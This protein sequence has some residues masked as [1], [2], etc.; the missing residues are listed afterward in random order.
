MLPTLL[1]SRPTVCFGR[2]T[3]KLPEEPQPQ[4]SQ[5][6]QDDLEVGHQAS[7]HAWQ[8]LRQTVTFKTLIPFD[9]TSTFEANARLAIRGAMFLYLAGVPN[10]FQLA[11]A[12]PFFENNPI[13][14]SASIVMFVFT[15][16]KSVGET[17]EFAG[18]G[19]VGAVL[20]AIAGGLLFLPFP[21]GVESSNYDDPA[22]LFATLMAILTVFSTLLLNLSTL[23]Q[24]FM[25]S[26]YV[27]HWMQFVDPTRDKR[28][29]YTFLGVDLH[30]NV[31]IGLESVKTSA[32]GCVLA[33]LV[34]LLPYPF[35]SIRKAK[36]VSKDMVSIFGDTWETALAMY[37]S[38]SAN[39]HEQSKIR[40]DLQRI[41]THIGTF[42]SHIT[43]SWWEAVFV[44]KYRRVRFLMTY[45]DDMAMQ[46]IDVFTHVI[47]SCL[48]EDFGETHS[49]LMAGC[50][51]HVQRLIHSAQELLNLSTDLAWE[52]GVRSTADK[53]GLSHGMDAVNQ[54]IATLTR[55]FNA[56]KCDM[57]LDYLN[58]E[59]IDE[60][61]FCFSA[62]KCGRLV[63][64]FAEVLL[65]EDK[66]ARGEPG[67]KPPK[68]VSLVRESKCFSKVFD[69]SV[70]LE[71]KHLNFAARNSLSTL[72]C[73]AIGYFGYSKMIKPFNAEIASTTGV[74]LSKFIGSSMTANL[75]RLQGVVLGVVIGELM[76]SLLGWCT[77][78]AWI[79]LS[80]F[81]IAWVSV[82][83]FAYFNSEVY[84]T[85]GCLMAAYGAQQMLMGCTS[86]VVQPATTYHKVVNCV[87]AIGVMSIVDLILNLGLPSKA[88]LRSYTEAWTKLREETTSLFS[89]DVQDSGF[90]K[91]QISDAIS[92]AEALAAEAAQEPRF[93]KNPWRG[94]AFKAGLKS[95]HAVRLA[96]SCIESQCAPNSDK[97]RWFMRLLENPAMQHVLEPVIEK[98]QKMDLFIENIDEKSVT[99]CE[100]L[101]HAKQD[102]TWKRMQGSIGILLHQS[103]RADSGLEVDSLEEDR[104]ALA[105][106]V[107]S[108]IYSIM[109][110]MEELQDAILVP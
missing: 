35:L 101:S 32:S 31:W 18:Q 42:Q 8:T 100:L 12:I 15:L 55:C 64:D 13:V 65:E 60:H 50:S 77:P 72:L 99:D 71:R 66:A 62:C 103:L 34:T 47:N 6:A 86:E 80:V 48:R 43:N 19:M 78:W 52:G 29:E 54:N 94:V 7:R 91:R 104:A 82:T 9:M 73:L 102:D 51:E 63:C 37:G 16:Y 25:L 105:S 56:R 81:L 96:L 24:I 69:R 90:P 45:L 70:I 59:M 68:R 76:F 110:A 36:S 20:A 58:L 97:E 41:Q 5:A 4:A 28:C 95:I 98:M 17:I 27:W 38:H 39:A 21:N 14:S 107:L 93:W 88:A 108:C 2:R 57:G 3:G 84:S 46:N 10:L 85:M 22:L 87:V 106:F 74:L 33:I 49:Q 11:D 83:L 23:A 67:A 75:N 89:A 1:T 79:A 26:N 92:D 61:V 30:S 109:T 53:E 44:P 40:H